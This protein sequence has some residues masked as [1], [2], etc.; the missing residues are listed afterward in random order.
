MPDIFHVYASLGRYNYMELDLPASDYEMLDLMERLR[1]EPGQPPYME[2][3]K[4]REGYGYLGKCICE[5]PDIYQFNALARKLAEFTSVLD[6]A[7]FEGM[8]GVEMRK[9]SVPIEIP[10]LIDFAHSTEYC[11][12][13]EN[14]MTDHQ[15][16][17]F[18]VDNDFIADAVDL[19]DAAL[20]LLDYGK[21]GREHREQTKGVYTGFG[22]VEVYG[23]VRHVSETMDF[24][25]RK[26]PAS[27]NRRPA[28]RKMWRRESWRSLSVRKM[29]KRSC[30]TL[31]F[32]AMAALCWSGTRPSSQGTVW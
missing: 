12:V 21:I 8:V 9:G 32:R 30:R 3:L 29:R 26:P 6:M 15:L 28:V 4:I 7:A 1:L 5:Q 13:A 17:K 23:D 25:P 31:T 18:L 11:H 19:P 14:A 10:K 2:V 16:G 27:L 22:Y 24:Q 20:E